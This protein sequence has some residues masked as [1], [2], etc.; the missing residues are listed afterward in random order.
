MQKVVVVGYGFWKRQLGGGTDAIGKTIEVGDGRY[1]IIGVAPQGFTGTEMRDVDVWV[2]IAA[3]AGPADGKGSRLGDDA[4]LAVVARCRAI[5]ARR[6]A[7]SMR[8]RKRRRCIAT[9]RASES[10]NRR[11]LCS[12][13]SIR[14]SW[15]LGR[16]FPGRS[17]WTWGLSGTGNETK[18]SALLMGVALMVLLIACANVANLLLVRALGR[19]RE[20]AVRLALGVSRGRLVSQLI[21][22]GIC[23]RSSAPRGRSASR[24][25]VRNSCDDG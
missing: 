20:I 6:D 16:S 2:P 15:S 19:R 18:I 1:T 10:R 12:R 8:R 25:S 21:V 7:R 17:L 11:R 5:E 13:A 14:S 24:R 3:A 4:E 22:E 23:S 9:G